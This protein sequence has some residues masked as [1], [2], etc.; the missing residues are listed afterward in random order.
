MF[1]F[2]A[3]QGILDPIT[4]L[5]Q[6]GIRFASTGLQAFFGY[7]TDYREPG[8]LQVA[9]ERLWLGFTS[10]VKNSFGRKLISGIMSFVEPTGGY[11]LKS[12]MAKPDLQVQGGVSLHTR[13]R[14]IRSVLPIASRVL[15]AIA[16]PNARRQR[17]IQIGNLALAEAQKEAQVSGNDL[18]TRLGEAQVLKTD[19]LL[20]STLFTNLFRGSWQPR[21]VSLN[22]VNQLLKH[23]LGTTGG[24]WH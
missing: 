9:G 12:V 22:L 4:P 23:F 10:L 6:D 8:L 19:L 18:Y 15:L 16:F 20:F 14:I 3:V 11:H 24:D 1:S 7:K 17:G 5:G 21:M 13:F 2:G